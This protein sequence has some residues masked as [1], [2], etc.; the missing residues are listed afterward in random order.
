MTQPNPIRVL[1]V[2]DHAMVRKGLSAFLLVMNDLELS[3]QAKD[4]TDALRLCEQLSPDVVLMDLMMPVMD[5][6][7]ATREIRE[8]WP[9][10]KVIALTSFPE[11][12]LVHQ[13][14]EAGAI[15]YLLKDVTAEE[16]GDAIRAAYAGKPTLAPEAT[17]ALIQGANK[18]FEPGHDLTPRERE[19][20]TLIVKGLSNPE[21][22]KRLSISRATASVHVSNILSK[23]GVSNR[24]E[25]TNLALRHNLV[26]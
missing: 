21:I 5:G 19:V 11:E 23:L 3:G 4:G 15:G 9:K 26:E 12:K 1:I 22:G 17:R 25:A 13:A 6:V 7:T 2:D 8:R 10:I 20:L 24:V 16:L 14:L 18:G